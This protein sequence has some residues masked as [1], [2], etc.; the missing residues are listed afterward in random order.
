[1]KTNREKRGVADS[2]HNVQAT[3]ANF[4][5]EAT[6][7]MASVKMTVH[8]TDVLMLIYPL[9]SQVNVKAHSAGASEVHPTYM[10]LCSAAFRNLHN[11]VFWEYLFN[12]I[13]YQS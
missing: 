8:S 11:R 3:L 12:L 13:V 4:C 2:L 6:G 7:T 9:R 10:Y 5:L 1:M